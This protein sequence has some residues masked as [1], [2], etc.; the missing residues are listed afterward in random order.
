MMSDTRT[1]IVRY[2]T[3]S[4]TLYI[5]T[6]KD[7]AAKGFEDD[8][9]IVWRYA[10]GGELI[11]ATIM[12]FYDLWAGDSEHLAHQIADKF[13]IPEPQAQVVVDRGLSLH[14]TE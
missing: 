8:R 11:G 13:H 4:D 12:D 10:T 2:D 14:E 3:R 5:A 1:F 6:T 9:G 7:P